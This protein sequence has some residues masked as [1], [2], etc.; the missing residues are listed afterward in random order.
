MSENNKYEQFDVGEE[1][2]NPKRSKLDAAERRKYRIVIILLILISLFLIIMLFYSKR[3]NENFQNESMDKESL[4]FLLISDLHDNEDNLALLLNKVQPKKYNYI[5]YLG[6]FVKMTPGQQNSSEH[7]NIYEERMKKYLQK[8]E[9][10]APVLYIPG[11]N[12]PYTIYEKNSPK[13]TEISKNIHNRYIKIKDDLYIM[14]LGG[15]VPILNGGNM[16]KM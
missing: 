11:N 7:A 8:L 5:F 16:I 13:L 12:E 4:K 10:I 2:N 3:K 14:G 1:N 15:C 9:Q 6:D